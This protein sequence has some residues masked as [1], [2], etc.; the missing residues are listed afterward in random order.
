MAKLNLYDFSR[1]EL[2]DLL[3]EGGFSSYHADRVWRGLYR[4][5]VSTIDALDVRAEVMALLAHSAE[6]PIPTT[7]KNRS[8]QRRLHAQIPAA[9]DNRPD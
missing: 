3:Q 2:V 7:L 4:D 6:I 5:R 8:Q 9:T 1:A